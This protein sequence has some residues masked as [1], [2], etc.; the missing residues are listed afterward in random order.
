[1]LGTAQG[2]VNNTRFAV[3]VPGRTGCN[4]TPDTHWAHRAG[5]RIELDISACRGGCGPGASSTARKASHGSS[6]PTGASAAATTVPAPR[7]AGAP[8]RSEHGTRFEITELSKVLLTRG[9]ARA[10]E[11]ALIDSNPHF[12][13]EINSISKKHEYYD[14]AV[15]WGNAWLAANGL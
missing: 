7:R 6:F 1:M 5:D 10:I 3:C 2:R 13:N 8:D 14:D 15:A 11:L 12:V 9:E 4:I